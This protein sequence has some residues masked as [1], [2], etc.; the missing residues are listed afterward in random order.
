MVVFVVYNINSDNRS[1][2][3]SNTYINNHNKKCPNNNNTSP[4]ISFRRICLLS[5]CGGRGVQENAFSMA[6]LAEELIPC[7]KFIIPALLLTK[8]LV[9][10]STG[11]GGFQ[12]E[13]CKDAVVR[14]T[15]VLPQY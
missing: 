5:C 11:A 1:R 12:Q 10:E 8:D 9:E 7:N 14:R 13:L 4:G 15:F 3:I 6:W 2:S